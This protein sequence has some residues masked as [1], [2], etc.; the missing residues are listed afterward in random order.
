MTRDQVLQELNGRFSQSILGIQDKS[1]K[2]VY[3][4]IDPAAL[5]DVCTM[6]FR[7]FEARF[8]TA[9]GVDTRGCIE[10]LYHFLVEPINLMISVRVALDREA[11]V[12]DSLTG[13]FAAADFIERE[14]HELLGVNFRGHDTPRRLLLPEQWP[15]GVQPLRRDYQ[16]WDPA[17]VRDRGVR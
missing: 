17:A 5:T 14:I 1:P 11:P 13:L 4:A 10:I 9:S 2:R 6:L 12:V 8:C 15:E 3:V 16:E 7:E